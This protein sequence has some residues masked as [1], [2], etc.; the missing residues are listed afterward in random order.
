[1]KTKSL[2]RI[3]VA[4]SAVGTGLLFPATGATQPAGLVFEVGFSSSNSVRNISGY[5][6]TNLSQVNATNDYDATVAVDDRGKVLA[7]GEVS[8]AYT[9]NSGAMMAK[10]KM[11]TVKGVPSADLKGAQKNVVVLGTGTPGLPT[12]PTIANGN[13]K[14][15]FQFPAS[16]PPEV[17]L[18]T[19][20]GARGGFLGVTNSKG[21]WSAAR[22]GVDGYYSEFPTN[23]S[24]GVI[25]WTF[26]FYVY[27]NDVDGR[28]YA[29]NAIL[30]FATNRASNGIVQYVETKFAET[31]AS[32]SHK[33]GGWTAQFNKP[34]NGDILARMSVKDITPTNPSAGSVG[35]KFLGQSGSGPAG[36]F[37]P[38]Y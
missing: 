19:K 35:Y 16:E 26:G 37:S 3:L 27:T 1:M 28:T 8:G 9:T 32:F 5:Y 11:K 18:V 21:N 33:T 38:V 10:G 22:A 15:T 2:P 6:Q 30:K 24:A 23:T 17:A 31:P 34:T 25:P 14:M 12:T 20:A 36:E 4:F 13:G 29:G 7:S